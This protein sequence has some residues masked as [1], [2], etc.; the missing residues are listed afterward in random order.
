VRERVAWPR[1]TDSG[2][3]WVEDI[4]VLAPTS[5]RATTDL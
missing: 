5:T 2:K 3:I 4:D 1:R